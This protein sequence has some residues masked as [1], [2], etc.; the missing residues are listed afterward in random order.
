ML[1]YLNSFFY[2]LKYSGITACYTSIKR[3]NPSFVP[4]LFQIPNYHFNLMKLF[5]GL[6]FILALVAL[7]GCQKELAGDIIAAGNTVD[8]TGA[9]GT[10]SQ[11]GTYTYY[12]QATIDGVNYKE[13]VTDNNGYIAGS[14]AS[15]NDDV[16]VSGGIN[17]MDTTKK[18]TTF[19]V[20]KGTLHNYLTLTD[21]QFKAFFSPGTYPYS[22]EAIDGIIVGWGDKNGNSWD[23]DQ[24]ARQEVY[25]PLPLLKM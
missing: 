5:S 3:K 20:T 7:T 11:S 2:C 1:N 19:G 12:Y 10:G 8:S 24:G 6:L 4:G 13:I 9:G 21:S 16:V 25:L 23:T 15:G 17:I 14:G 18:G 22:K